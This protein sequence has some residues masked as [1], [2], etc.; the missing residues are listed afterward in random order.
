[1]A[2]I[3]LL[4]KL[5]QQQ[6][7][8]GSGGDGGLVEEKKIFGMSFGGGG[9][10][11]LTKVQQ[12]K[13]I[14]LAVGFVSIF[15]GRSWLTGTYLPEKLV[16]PQAQLAQAQA[17]VAQ[18]EEEIKRIATI[19]E[20]LVQY[21]KQVGEIKAKIDAIR[22][23]REGQRD[24]VLR[25]VDYIVQQMPEPVWISKIVLE[26]KPG[27]EISLD[28]KSMNYQNISTFLA[29]LQKGVFFPTWKLEQTQREIMERAN[30]QKHAAMT[31]SIKGEVANIR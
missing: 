22:R 10:I 14:L 24:R 29:R 28:G 26:P 25:M 7:T 1:V 9:G 21:E 12:I 19:R 18:K 5:E 4:K 30:G 8:D 23:V 2:G 20:E 17:D 13:L 3:N 31:F 6:A 16:E 11:E 27:S 15:V